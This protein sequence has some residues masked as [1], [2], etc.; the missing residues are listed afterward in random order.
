V[1]IGG[2]TTTEGSTRGRRDEPHVGVILGQTRE[3]LGQSL[4]DVSRDLRIRRAFLEAIEEGRY[5]G[6]P[7]AAYTLG[8]IRTYAEHLGLEGDEI[9]RRFK[10]ESGQAAPKSKLNFPSPMSESTAP[11]AAVLLIGALIAVAA[12]GIWYLSSNRYLDVAELVVPLPEHLRKLLPGEQRSVTVPV[13]PAARPAA[14][15][16]STTSD[17]AKP[18][19]AAEVVASQP[20][21]AAPAAP[22]ASVPPVPAEVNTAAAPPVA[23]DPAAAPAPNRDP[24][25]AAMDSAAAGRVVLRANADAWV[26]VR[27]SGV[28]TP[29]LSRLMKAG[30][31]FVVPDRSGLT[32]MT[33]NAGGLEVTVDGRPVPSLGKSGTVRRNVSLAPESL[34]A[35]PTAAN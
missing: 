25:G 34:S 35:L 19:P 33:G 9:V 28:R 15:V 21:R 6:L 2:A 10:L 3:A 14:E 31:T 12:Y 5:D 24:N 22:A 20:E 4:S 27:E 32:L 29:L 17:P 13:P 8:F 11:K 23:P 26:E 18:P 7:G 30:E 16:A 1:A